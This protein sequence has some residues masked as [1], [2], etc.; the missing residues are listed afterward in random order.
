MYRL[1][2]KDARI[3]K[4]KSLLDIISDYTVI[5]VETTGLSIYEC[6]VIELS[7]VRV[8]NNEIVEEYTQLVKPTKSI[9]IEIVKL[10]G[11][12]DEMVSDMPYISDVLQDYINFIG[13]D[14]L[15][16]HN[17]NSFDINIIYDLCENCLHKSLRNDFIDTVRF[18]NYCNIDT[19]DSKLDTLCNYYNIT[20][21]QRHRSLWDCKANHLL[22]QSLIKDF[23]GQINKRP[24]DNNKKSY[25]NKKQF[26][27][28]KNSSETIA[29]RAM[30]E[31]LQY[32]LENKAFDIKTLSRLK[33]WIESS[34]DY[35]NKYPFNDIYKL[36]KDVLEDNK[37]DE[38]EIVELTN[39]FNIIVDPL[40]FRENDVFCENINGKVICLTGNFKKGSK[41]NIKSELEKNGASIS[42]N[43]TRKVNILLVGSLGN[44]NWQCGNYGSKIKKAME[45][46]EKGL[47]I[48][49]IGEED[50]FNNLYSNKI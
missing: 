48:K 22:Y 15:V 44:E 40:K 29:L 37:I 34:D 1:D 27:K 2:G 11:I 30:K 45:Y 3:N 13:D 43:V 42:N 24:T 49:I 31:D 41:D 18:S 7:A 8:R 14:V 28:I 5:D 26:I 12:T 9:P 46:Q 17:I 4:G 19:V 21:E 38:D 16:G 36:I 10:T 23:T 6:E 35:I 39:L 47:D 32:V 25:N 20:N 33:E 50:F